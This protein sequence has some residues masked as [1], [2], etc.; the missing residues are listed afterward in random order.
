M[1]SAPSSHP[2]LEK[3]ASQRLIPLTFPFNASWQTAI[4]FSAQMPHQHSKLPINT[5][6]LETQGKKKKMYGRPKTSHSNTLPM[7]L[8]KG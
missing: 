4:P 5:S 8:R 7:R 3:G 1:Q 2:F 6:S